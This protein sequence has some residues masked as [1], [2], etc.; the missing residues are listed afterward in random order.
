M[1][2]VGA[3][4]Q[5]AGFGDFSGRAN[6][7]DMLM[8]NSN[9]GAFEV[10]DISNNAIT[11]AAGMG[12]VGAPWQVAGF[13]DF[14]GHA[15]ETDMLMRNA[16]TGAFE[17]YD[18]SNNAITSAAGMGQVGMEW[19]V[20]GFGD[21]SGNANETDM[22]M[23]DSSTGAFELYDISNNAITPQPHGSSRNGMVGR[24][25]RRRSA[26]YIKCAT[27]SSDGV[28]RHDR[29]RKQRAGSLLGALNNP[30]DTPDN[31]ACIIPA[32][33]RCT[34]SNRVPH[35][36]LSAANF[37]RCKNNVIGPFRI[38]IALQPSVGCWRYSVSCWRAPAAADNP[39]SAGHDV[40]PKSTQLIIR[41]FSS[42]SS[43]L[44]K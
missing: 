41:G 32:T 29:S 39:G 18:I 6:E 27:R 31:T 44:S 24:W 43:R 5:V 11:S 4:W 37:L 1:G 3:Q 13:G 22:L 38:D 25:H 15:N 30:A 19:Q 9:T 12:Q 26:G 23:R 20:A 36:R 40:L 14:S 21:F 10:Y 17:V 7:T 42:K 33:F 8:Q 16:N 2:Q 35:P 34:A 28:V